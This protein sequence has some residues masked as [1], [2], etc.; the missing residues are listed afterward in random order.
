MWGNHYRRQHHQIRAGPIPTCVGQPVCDFVRTSFFGAYPHVCGATGHFF[1]GISPHPGL[2]P[3]VWGNRHVVQHITTTSGPI[4]TCVGQPSA[5]SRCVKPSEAYPHVC[6]ATNQSPFL[7]L[8]FSGLSP[9]VWGN[10]LLPWTKYSCYGPIPTCVGQPYHC[11]FLS[12]DFAAYPHVCGATQFKKSV[13]SS[14]LG[15]SPRVWGN[16]RCTLC[17]PSRLRPIP[18]CVGQPTDKPTKGSPKRAY[19]HVCGATRADD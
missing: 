11:P 12:S 13:G 10:R 1:V 9:R 2:S 4:P 18:T 8:L 14:I 3:R 15:L 17:Q 19:P 5:T 6:G 7:C 16:L